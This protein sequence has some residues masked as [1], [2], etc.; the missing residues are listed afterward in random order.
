MICNRAWRIITSSKSYGGGK[1]CR[2][3]AISSTI[4]SVV[5][6]TVLLQLQQ[7]ESNIWTITCK[8][9][10]TPSHQD[11]TNWMTT[12]SQKRNWT[13]SVMISAMNNWTSWKWTAGVNQ[14][15]CFQEDGYIWN[16]RASSIINE[17]RRYWD[18][19]SQ[20]QSSGTITWRNI[21]VQKQSITTSTGKNLEE[22]D[23][24]TQTFQD[25]LP[26][27]AADGYQRIT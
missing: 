16:V 13:T 10:F 3:A 15:S 6:R 22:P 2:V 14:P 18:R 26:S 24:K 19:Q 9:N 20:E 11:K 7:V 27:Y 1:F 8:L 23:T 12:S 4:A 5:L 21:A 17:S 25:T